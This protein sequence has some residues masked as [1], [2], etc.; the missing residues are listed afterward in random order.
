MNF[1]EYLIESDWEEFESVI[2]E[3]IESYEKTGILNESLLSSLSAKLSSGIEFIKEFA[4]ALGADLLDILKLFKEKVLFTFFSKIKWSISELVNLV[5][6]GYKLWKDLHNIIAEYISQNKIVK[7]TNDK[8]SDLD[9]FL[10]KHPLIKKAGS[11]VVVGFLIYQWTSM[12]SFTSDIEFDFDQSVLFEAIKGNFSLADLF[13]T[14]DGIKMLLFIATGVLT[15]LSF[16]WPGNA[17]LLFGLSIVYTIAKKKHPA[18][19]KAIIKNVK[20]YKS[21]LA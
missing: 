9:A 8:L 14:P 11:L 21:V 12:I 15:G 4:K 19:S 2:S 16:P 3:L 7:W 20:K 13:A 18:I 5:K 10:E 1:R 17:W 6:K